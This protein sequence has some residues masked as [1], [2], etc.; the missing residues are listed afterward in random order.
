MTLGKPE[1]IRRSWVVRRRQGAVRVGAFG[2]DFGLETCSSL[3]LL[4][5][6]PA[7]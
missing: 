1:D 3:E 6:T 5:A 7:S 2:T 4:A